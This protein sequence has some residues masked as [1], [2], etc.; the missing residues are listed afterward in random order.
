VPHPRSCAQIRP[1]SLDFICAKLKKGGDDAARLTKLY[2]K[3]LQQTGSQPSL[4]AFAPDAITSCTGMT[5]TLRDSFESPWAS[6]LVHR[7]EQKYLL[8][9]RHGVCPSSTSSGMSHGQLVRAFCL[10]QPVLLVLVA[11]GIMW[12]HFTYPGPCLWPS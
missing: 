4:G 8:R 11:H 7:L 6:S 5:H 12:T 1:S 3:T 2:T 9:R 10:S